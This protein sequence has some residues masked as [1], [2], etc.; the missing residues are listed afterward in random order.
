MLF[1]IPIEDKSSQP[2]EK[3][4][5]GKLFDD[6][7]LF[8]SYEYGIFF[9]KLFNFPG[10]WKIS[11]V[12]P[13]SRCRTEEGREWLGKGR[14]TS[15]AVGAQNYCYKTFKTF[16]AVCVQRGKEEI[17]HAFFIKVKTNP[18]MC[19]QFCV[20]LCVYLSL[21]SMLHVLL[22]MPNEHNDHRALVA[23]F[24]FI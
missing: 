9:Y 15:R 20:F 18:K 19:A 12:Y 13:A 8:I 22:Q 11:Q 10:N 1:V 23:S 17:R 14:M 21:F 5:W 3:R 24:F 16:M 6:V 7:F 2:I 4:M